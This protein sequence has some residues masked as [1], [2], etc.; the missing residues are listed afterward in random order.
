ME[1]RAILTS[2]VLAA[3]GVIKPLMSAHCRSQHFPWRLKL[4]LHFSS[5]LFI[6][7]AQSIP[8][9]FAWPSLRVPGIFPHLDLHLGS[10]LAAVLWQEGGTRRKEIKPSFHLNLTWILDTVQR[11]SLWFI[12]RSQQVTSC[13]HPG[14]ARSVIQDYE[15]QGIDSVAAVCFDL[16][17]KQTSVSKA[18]TRDLRLLTSSTLSIVTCF[19]L[20]SAM[21]T[22]VLVPR[23][24]I[25]KLYSIDATAV[26][27]N[28][29]SGN[30]WQTRFNRGNYWSFM[31]LETVWQWV[32]YIR[33]ATLLIVRDTGV[34]SV[35]LTDL[36][37]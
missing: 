31:F 4:C 30:K 34:S 6:L 25:C 15:F 1:S 8:C 29:L 14:A 26:F 9:L 5:D 10:R 35:H 36:R 3:A 21:A 19:T 16:Q 2:R 17:A 11:S 7:K 20:F 18:E 13:R 22:L 24:S 23:F 32:L 33:E 12:V 37:D 27:H 28:F